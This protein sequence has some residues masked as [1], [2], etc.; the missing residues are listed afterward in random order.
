MY[1]EIPCIC[2]HKSNLFECVFNE[3]KLKLTPCHTLTEGQCVT[4][5]RMGAKTKGNGPS[6]ASAG[7]SGAKISR[8]VLHM[9]MK[10]NTAVAPPKHIY[11]TH[12]SSWANRLHCFT[13]LSCPVLHEHVEIKGK[14]FSFRPFCDTFKDFGVPIVFRTAGEAMLT[15]TGSS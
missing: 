4:V 10:N 1:R 14:G 5:K 11:L 13:V 9:A 7:S 3:V 2:F 15:K 12:S 6:P 8:F